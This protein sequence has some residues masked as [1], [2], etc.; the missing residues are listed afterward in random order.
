MSKISYV[1]GTYC[2]HS[3][4]AIH[5]EDRGYQFADGVYEV[6]AVINKKIVDYDGHIKRLY[7]SLNE[8][9]IESPIA[10]EAYLFHIKNIIKKNNIIDGLIYLQVTRGVAKRDFKFPKNIKASLVI[11]AKYFSM[12]EYHEKFKKGIKVKI[13]NDLRWKRV[14]IKTLNL[15]P[16]VLAKQQAVEYDCEEAWMIDN[17]GYITEGSSSNAWIL[18][19]DKLITTPTSNAI[20]NGITRTSLLKALKK[21]NI[22]LIER[23]F[24]KEDIKKANEAFITSATQFVMPV[25]KIDKNLVGKGKIGKYAH[26]FKD[27]YLEAVQL[28]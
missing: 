7:R 12:D 26:I 14:D 19:N 15:L 3:N 11:I 4:A 22:K 17:D 6:F 20:L 16:P 2:N 10:K 28:K 23:R 24:N 8:I 27:A 13:V 18:I 21:N 5:I 25:I 9:R 1:N